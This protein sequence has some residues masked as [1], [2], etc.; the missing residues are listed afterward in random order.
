M[1]DHLR[2]AKLLRQKIRYAYA[3]EEARKL[4]ITTRR[5]LRLRREVLAATRGEQE[6]RIIGSVESNLNQYVLVRANCFDG[7]SQ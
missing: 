4:H 5:Y 2:E 1:R 7:A 6:D 3:R